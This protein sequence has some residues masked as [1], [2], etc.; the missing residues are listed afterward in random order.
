ML[1][2][3]TVNEKVP[4]LKPGQ[5]WTGVTGT[6]DWTSGKYQCPLKTRLIYETHNS[7]YSKYVFMKLKSCGPNDEPWGAPATF[8]TLFVPLMPPL[9]SI[10][11]FTLKFDNYLSM[12]V[13]AVVVNWC[14][15]V[16]SS[17]SELTSEITTPRASYLGS[18]GV[19]EW[20]LPPCWRETSPELR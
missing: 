9:P 5:D 6:Q 20:R 15:C 2:S 12:V 7:T 17:Q 11:Q 19:T 18:I 4:R 13:G 1:L 3:F 14:V 10:Q 8:K 16:Q